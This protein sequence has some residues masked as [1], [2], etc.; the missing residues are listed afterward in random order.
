MA[1]KLNLCNFHCFV[2]YVTLRFLTKIVLQL[3]YFKIKQNAY[4]QVFILNRQKMFRL[5]LSH[6]FINQIGHKYK[7]LSKKLNALIRAL[8][9]CSIYSSKCFVQQKVSEMLFMVLNGSNLV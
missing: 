4:K 8:D 5:K 9:Q 3:H 7:I 6:T 1:Q 2:S